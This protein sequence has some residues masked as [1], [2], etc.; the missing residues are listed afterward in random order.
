[1]QLIIISKI[2]AVDSDRKLEQI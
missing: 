2:N 1:M